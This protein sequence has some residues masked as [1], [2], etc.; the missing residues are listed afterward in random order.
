MRQMNNLITCQWWL[1]PK[2]IDVVDHPTE[3]HRQVFQWRSNP[4]NWTPY[5]VSLPAKQKRGSPYLDLL[6]SRIDVASAINFTRKWGLLEVDQ[7]LARSLGWANLASEHLDLDKS[8]Y[9]HVARVREIANYIRRGEFESAYEIL[10]YRRLEDRPFDP[11][12]RL[13]PGFI[14]HTAKGSGSPHFCLEAPTLKDF[15][16][17]QLLVSL[18]NRSELKVCAYCGELFEAGS[19]RGK[20]SD[21]KY[22]TPAHRKAGCEKRKRQLQLSATDG[23]PVA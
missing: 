11:L 19:G 20:R 1:D 5:R 22:C 14:I 6:R 13:N 8:F 2:G 17:A 23:P 21:S 12:F 16:G 15:I 9:S 4:A 10:N 18:C 3:R 7:D